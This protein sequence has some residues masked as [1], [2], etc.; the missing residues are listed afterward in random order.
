MFDIGWSE[1]LVVAVVVIVV[2]G[3]K[4]L[5]AMLRTFGRTMGYMR[6]AAND[7]KRQFEDAIREAERE[8]GLEEAR[9]DLQSIAQMDPVRDAQKEI[10]DAVRATRLPPGPVVGARRPPAPAPKPAADLAHEAAPAKT[11]A[12]GAEHGSDAA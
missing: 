3:P 11:G 1:L 9:K 5:P 7:F 4:E 10:D 2:V 8:A 12:V 6:R